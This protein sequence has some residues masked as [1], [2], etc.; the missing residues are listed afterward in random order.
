MWPTTGLPVY[1][2]AKW[3]VIG[4]TTSMA[5]STVD[6]QPLDICVSYLIEHNSS[7][8]FQAEFIWAHINC[9]L[10]WTHSSLIEPNSSAHFEAE[11]SGVHYVP[12]IQIMTCKLG[13]LAVGTC[14]YVNV[15]H[16]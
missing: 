5:V 15:S 9:P 4:F 8:Y 2:A 14:T 6:I 11:L 16:L 3:G 1:A 12:H 7:T 10:Y 13:F